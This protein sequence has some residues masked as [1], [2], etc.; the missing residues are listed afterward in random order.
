MFFHS[1]YG[2][3]GSIPVS[4]TIETQSPENAMFSGFC[5]NFNFTPCVSDLFL[6]NFPAWQKTMTR[7]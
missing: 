4:R 6:V 2:V 5:F 7:R 3:F 1:K